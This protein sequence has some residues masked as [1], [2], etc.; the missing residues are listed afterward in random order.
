MAQRRE[1]KSIRKP[2]RASKRIVGLS[3]EPVP[4]PR[5]T[6]FLPPELKLAIVGCMGKYEL[7]KVRLLSREWSMFATPLLF[8]K[9]YI[10]PR[11]IDL[12]VFNNITQHPV[13]GPAVREVI[14]DTSR[15]QDGI[16]RRDYFDRLCYDLNHCFVHDN[17]GLEWRFYPLVRALKSANSRAQ[18]SEHSRD[19]LYERHRKDDLVRS[20]YKRW[21][22]Y[23]K[24]ERWTAE[25]LPSI[26]S[27]PKASKNPTEC[28]HLL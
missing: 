25:Q 5:K 22:R 28:V 9:V 23:A 11:K 4:E 3:V 12:T 19:E 10:S 15:F 18:F 13:L 17:I 6:V 26:L 16:S 1:G 7:K 24:S 20:G 27:S 2:R 21:R 8:D 14:Y